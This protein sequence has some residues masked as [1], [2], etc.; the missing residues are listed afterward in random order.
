MIVDR[1]Y[2][3]FNP[4]QFTLA[5]RIQFYSTGSTSYFLDYYGNSSNF[6]SCYINTGGTIWFEHM[7]GGTSVTTGC[8]PTMILGTS[9]NLLFRASTKNTIDS[10][11]HLKLDFGETTSDITAAKTTALGTFAAADA[12]FSIGQNWY[13]NGTNCFDGRIWL[14]IDERAWSDSEVSDFI[15][16]GNPLEPI[17]ADYTKF[18]LAGETGST[19]SAPVGIYYDSANATQFEHFENS[20]TG[21]TGID[22]TLTAETTNPLRD[23]QSLSIAGET[24]GGYAYKSFDVTGSINYMV[25][26]SLSGTTGQ[27][28]G[29]QVVGNNSGL[30]TASTGDTFSAAGGDEVRMITFTAGASDTSVEVR[31]FDNLSGTGYYWNGEFF[32]TT[33]W[34]NMTVN[35]ED[36]GA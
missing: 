34:N 13:N 17:V 29:I 31:L 10:V 26:V 7:A 30:I 4:H 28:A 8:T 3:N 9:Y 1:N 14:Q 20:V 27:I 18:M 5:F 11:N 15:N 23:A 16:S 24:Y 2:A 12:T 35:W 33:T 19:N 32:S 22:S 25:E 6:I 36:L 21:W